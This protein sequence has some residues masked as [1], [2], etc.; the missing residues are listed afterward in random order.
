MSHNN[1]NMSKYNKIALFHNFNCKFFNN[2]DRA[3]WKI[4]FS[5]PKTAEN[6]YFLSCA[7]FL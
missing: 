6:D 2:R 7:F 3:I 5:A 4:E 1:Y